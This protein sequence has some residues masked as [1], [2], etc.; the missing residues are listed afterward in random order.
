MVPLDAEVLRHLSRF[1]GDRCGVATSPR[2]RALPPDCWCPSRSQVPLG[3]C[4]RPPWLRSLARG[5]TAHASR[6]RPVRRNRPPVAPLDASSMGPPGMALLGLA[7]GAPGRSSRG[8]CRLGGFGRPCP[9]PGDDGSARGALLV[10]ASRRSQTNRASCGGWGGGLCFSWLHSLSY[11]MA[12]RG[13]RPSCL[14]SESTWI[15]RPWA[16]P[17]S[18]LSGHARLA[19]LPSGR[20]PVSLIRTRSTAY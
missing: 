3:R 20:E 4:T 14:P 8:A 1:G 7:P 10:A 18:A 13:P 19:S 11:G 12:S 2:P 9:S 15:S 5:E 6:R 16:P 17:S